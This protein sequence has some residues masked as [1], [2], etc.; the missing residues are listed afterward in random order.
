[1]AQKRTIKMVTGFLKILGDQ[2][3][4]SG[5]AILIA[6]LASRCKTSIYEFNIVT[7]LAYFAIYNQL[8]SL[9]ILREYHRE[10]TFVRFWRVIITIGSFV[11]FAF[12]YVVHTVTYKEFDNLGWGRALYPAQALQCIFVAN[13]PVHFDILDSVV[14]VG[15]MTL[16]H[17]TV[18][19]DLYLPTT[20]WADW[21]IVVRFLAIFLR[22]NT[23]SKVE[24]REVIQ[25]AD[26]RYSAWLRPPN[27][28]DPKARISIWYLLHSF[29]L[30]YL[31]QISG[32]LLGF[33][34]GT[35]NIVSSIWLEDIKPSKGLRILSFGQI[36]ALGLL[37]LTF[38]AAVEILNGTYTLM[39]Y[40]SWVM[41]LIMYSQ[42]RKLRLLRVRQR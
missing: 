4:V 29:H 12:A 9:S 8:L 38:V 22:N 2:Q 35:A 39:A 37:L 26:A 6:G 14:T 16:L 33:T 10:H 31:S 3:L 13:K 1:M 36:V 32:L 25:I 21:E 5:L 18:I 11:L 7:N 15:T 34:Y 19:W 42:K 20:T 28:G 24:R 23:L 17:V 27:T 40:Q 30:T 41:G